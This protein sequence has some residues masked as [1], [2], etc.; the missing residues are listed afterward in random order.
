MRNFGQK[1]KKLREEA[2]ITPTQLADDSNLSLAYVSKL[3]SGKST[4]PSIRVCKSLADGLGMTLHDFLDKVGLTRVKKNG[5]PS[6]E[7]IKHA[8]RSQ[9][10]TPAQIEEIVK[11]A[12]FIRQS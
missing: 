8:F 10:F 6:S 1:L 7:I 2:G 3:E 11:Y 9:G 4:S 5:R 12:K